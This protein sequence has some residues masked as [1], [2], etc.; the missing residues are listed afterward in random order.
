MNNKKEN[1]R[2]QIFSFKAKSLMD[3]PIDSP[4]ER[5][6]AIY[7]P[8]DYL[9]S[10]KKR[11]PVIYF[12]HG[13]TGNIDNLSVTP[14]WNDNKNLPVDLIPPDVLKMFDL[15]NIP[16]Y[17]KFDELIQKGEFPPFIFVQ[18]DASLY[19]PHY[20][21]QT[22][23]SG[24]VKT[25]GSFYIN[26]P[27]TGN[28]SDFI[29]ND[30][31]EYMD[32]NYRTD[33]SKEKRALIG[34]SMGGYGAL[35]LYSNYP[36]RF[37]AVASLS[38]ANITFNLINHKMITPINEVLYGK[39]EAIKLGKTA[40]FDICDTFDLITSKSNL[41]IPSIKRNNKDEIIDFNKE[42]ALNW[43][44]YDLDTIIMQKVGKSPAS[45]RNTHLMLNCHKKD[46]YGFAN[47]TKK[48]HETLTMFG[49]S[50]NFEI[51]QDFRAKLAPHM[52]GIGYKI[53]PAIK[54]CV[55]FFN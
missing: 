22:E 42:A 15:D 23:I 20:L 36:E 33:S 37:N 53:L 26:S 50:H 1:K 16:S 52:L 30:V 21:G 17:V 9:D 40:I 47:E 35:Y 38:P 28:F 25:K 8:P 18:P 11:Y 48:L 54:F 43:K 44:N 55:Q 31:I 24:A 10:K 13:Y 29:I 2:Y 5:K 19:L 12:I 3:N 39:D 51:Y 27:Y 41:L 49:I 14:R 34:P 4:V 46:D 7:L 32:T 6:L 45:F